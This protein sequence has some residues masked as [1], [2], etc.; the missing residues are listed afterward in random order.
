M[1]NGE[2][3]A[4]DAENAR[5]TSDCQIPVVRERVCDLEHAQGQLGALRFADGRRL[6][7]DFVFT[8]RGD[9]YYSQIA[10]QL[11]AKTDGEGQIV[12]DCGMRTNIP[13][14]FAAGCVTEANCQMIIAAGQGAAA[15]QAINRSLFEDGL[16]NQSFKARR[17]EQLR[18]GRAEA[19]ILEP[20]AG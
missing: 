7:V 8:T 1:T 11:G 10:K 20:K 6:K 17:L 3:P 9:I 15:A 12:V 13:G 19:A 16:K 14:L 5:W 4:W 18:N 2:A